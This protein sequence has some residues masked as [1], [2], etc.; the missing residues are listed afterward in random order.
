MILNM[1]RLPIAILGLLL[2]SCTNSRDPIVVVSGVSVGERSAEA[3]RL[4]FTLDLDNPNQ[5]SLRLSEFEYDV[6]INGTHA[7]SGT[8]AAEATL[9]STDHRQVIIPAIIRYD[10]MGW[11]QE[12]IPQ[13]VRF[14]VD[15]SMTYVAPGELSRTFREMGFPPPRSGFKREAELTLR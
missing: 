6:S 11:T 1:S 14:V 5:Q 4:D 3:L 7:Y 12:Q 13:T 9:A 8:R 10:T 15:G 2:A